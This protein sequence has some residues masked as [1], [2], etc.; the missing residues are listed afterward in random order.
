MEVIGVTAGAS[1]P[2]WM[3]KKVAQQIEGIRSRKETSVGRVLRYV[4]K[5][6]FQTNLVVSSGAFFFTYASLILSGRD[7]DFVHPSLS[8]LYIYAMHV[9][10]RFLDKGAGFYNDPERAAFFPAQGRSWPPAWQPSSVV[11]LL[12]HRLLPFGRS[13]LNILGCNTASRPRLGW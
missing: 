10:N 6:L 9:L 2:N 11:F 8:F 4:F 5:F 13:R 1:T 12:L 3:I 7:P